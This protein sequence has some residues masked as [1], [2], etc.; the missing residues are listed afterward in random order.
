[1]SKEI[2]KRQ[3]LYLFLGSKNQSVMLVVLS[4]KTESKTGNIQNVFF[5]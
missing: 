2:E 5:Y 1:M 3:S 4:L